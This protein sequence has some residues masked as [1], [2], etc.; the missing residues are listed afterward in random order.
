MEPVVGIFPSRAA[1]ERAA[2]E[3]RS[4]GFP[5]HRIELLLP[6]NHS[7]E[8]LEDE[9]PTEDAEG[10][11]M[12]QAVG[13]VVGGATGASAGFGIGAITA[14]L[15]IPGIGAVTAVGIAAAAVLGALGAAGGAAAGESLEDQSRT[16]VPRDDLPL[17]E[18]ALSEGKGVLFALVEDEDEAARARRILSATG[19]ES[20]ETAR[21]SWLEDSKSPDGESSAGPDLPARI[22]RRG[23][24]AALAPG[25]DGKPYTE[26]LPVLRVRDGLVALSPAFQEGYSAGAKLVKSRAEELSLRPE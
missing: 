8:P 13:A 12:G 5:G 7:P 2:R 6:G 19:G 17:Y 11:G 14:S 20:L 22:Y 18:E 4:G 3:I 25:M 21:A 26:V 24:Q 16:G 9:V 15:L 23:F 1:A 10:S